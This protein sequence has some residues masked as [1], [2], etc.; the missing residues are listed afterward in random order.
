MN[1]SGES[2]HDILSLLS[3]EMR[4]VSSA[5]SYRT[6]QSSQED[7]TLFTQS[8]I[9]VTLDVHSVRIIDCSASTQAHRSTHDHAWANFEL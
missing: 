5:Y 1:V 2:D 8:M 3:S 6:L 4:C 7:T 9:A